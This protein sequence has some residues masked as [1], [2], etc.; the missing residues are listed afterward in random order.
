MADNK[1]LYPMGYVQPKA[2]AKKTKTVKGWVVVSKRGRLEGF[3]FSQSKYSACYLFRFWV[4]DGEPDK[5]RDWSFFEE[6]GYRLVKAT[7]T[8]EI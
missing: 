7:V 1:K 2:K 3:S 4:A 5:V 6:R 8:V